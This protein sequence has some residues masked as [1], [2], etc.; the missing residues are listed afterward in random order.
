Y[1]IFVHVNSA[2]SDF[3][4][5]HFEDNTAPMSINAVHIDS[6]TADS[7][8]TDN[9]D[10]DYV[11]VHGGE[12]D[13]DITWRE[14]GTPW[15][16][17]DDVSFIDESHSVI[18]EGTHILFF[19]D[20][21]L[22]LHKGRLDILGTEDA[23]VVMEGS[24]DQA[25]WWNGLFFR[26]SVGGASQVEYLELRHAGKHGHANTRPAGIAI[27]RSLYSAEANIT[28]SLIEDIDTLDDEDPFGIYVHATGSVNQDICSANEFNNIAGQDCLID[29]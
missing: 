16:V 29:D 12:T 28:D 17:S 26:D 9:D 10:G 23:P 19:D 3:A 24:E 11:E 5:N 18:E 20:T 6:I 25:G 8:F 1:G 21:S 13:D 15:F 22:E 4:S 14:I 27:S 7:T 2:L